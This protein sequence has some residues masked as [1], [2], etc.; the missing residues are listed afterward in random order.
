M[1][2]IRGKPAHALQ[3]DLPGELAVEQVSAPEPFQW[4]VSDGVDPPRLNV[5]FGAGQVGSF[6]V[7]IRGRLGERGAVSTVS[8]PRI[9]VDGAVRQN[10]TIVVQTDPSY[11]AAAEQLTGCETILLR[12]TH[13]WLTEQQRPL[14]RLAVRSDDA[15]FG[16]QIL[17]TRR[18]PRVS[19]QTISNVRVTTRAFEETVLLDYTIRDA[20]VREVSF[21]LP[22]DLRNA[23]VNAPLLRSKSVEDVD[24]DPALVRVR[25][26][27]QDEVIGQFRVL[28]EHDR[29]LS[30][31]LRAVPIPVVESARVEQQFVALESAGRDEVIVD[32]QQ[33]LE[34]LSRQQ[35]KWRTLAA[36]LGDGVT[37]AFLAETGADAPRLVVRT[38]DRQAVETV[39]ARIAFAQT[40]LT[41]DASG[42]YR[43]TQQ[44]QVDNRTEQF[45]AVEL[46]VGAQLWTARVAGEAVKP[47]IGQ[48]GQIRV[49]LV[50]TAEGEQ[51]YAVE[52]KYGG[53]MAGVGRLANVDF[54]LIQTVNINVE[55]SQVRLYVPDTH[56]WFGFSGTMRR[57]DADEDFIASYLRYKTEQLTTFSKS[58]ASE[59]PYAR[60]R[61]LSNLKQLTSEVEQLQAQTRDYRGLSKE[62]DESLT[63]N[64]TALQ[65]AKEALQIQ[66]D[67]Q[68]EIPSVNNRRQLNA[69]FS[70]QDN[71][72]SRN[73]VNEQSDNFDIQTAASP[74][75]DRSGGREGQVQRQWFEAYQLR[76]ESLDA[77]RLEPEGENRVQL[78]AE[79]AKDTG[80]V[81]GKLNRYS[82]QV[83]PQGAPQKPP[84][85]AEPVSPRGRGESRS[86]DAGVD[87][88]ER[89]E[90]RLEEQQKGLPSSDTDDLF[91][92]PQSVDRSREDA[93]GIFDQ[94][95]AVSGPETAGP[96][97]RVPVVRGSGLGGG[98]LGGGFLGQAT[99]FASL[100]VQLPQRG[101]EYRFTT[102]RGD[103][104]IQ[105]R[106]IDDSLWLRL[107]KLAIVTGLILLVAACVRIIRR[108][109]YGG[110]VGPKLAILLIVI[111]LLMLVL[112]VAPLLGVILILAG[113]MRFALGNSASE[114]CAVT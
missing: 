69:Y 31:E 80:I 18:T 42:A 72:V 47:I 20:G 57:V 49:P 46:P 55:L 52:L 36:I 78:K 29:L 86:R 61:A 8:L 21:L 108:V 92:V 105:A 7:V 84:T 37:Q 100:D 56:R 22:S 33:Q 2:Q 17:L 12:Q 41:V 59:N 109:G 89:F 51:D 76:N 114:T 19:C 25:L 94:E 6:S 103:I 50:K 9:Y 98:G 40:T 54:P 106:A 67:Q 101:T 5:F 90:Q 87:K 74:E 81:S 39:G 28:V 91:D 95:S 97:F 45:L 30:A 96:Q 15:D 14:A 27:L 88:V 99:G 38:Q 13:G 66:A 24:G 71:S 68:L 16:G 3:F 26:E 10:T 75:D 11:N 34:P 112:G 32:S 79:K 4:S 60:V 43:G 65:R 64:T 63:A 110:I 48:Q 53:R 44:Y 85:T 35:E 73:L 82:L 93:D 1:M 62:L 111:G 104:K 107:R 70:Y 58:L 83:M 77:K 113:N 102:P 23:R